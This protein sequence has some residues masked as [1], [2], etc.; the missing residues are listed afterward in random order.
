MLAAS[1]HERANLPLAVFASTDYDQDTA[2]LQSGDRLAIFTDGVTEC[3][4]ETEEEFGQERL[5]AFLERS[6]SEEISIIKHRLIDA[7]KEHIGSAARSDDLTFI[8]V[9]IA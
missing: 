5:C 8:L 4:S 3:P 6:E 1:T 9:E 7:L 2:C